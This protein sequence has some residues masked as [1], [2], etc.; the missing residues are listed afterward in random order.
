[1]GAHRQEMHTT[2]VLKGY[3]IGRA[4][5]L[6]WPVSVSKKC[7]VEF[8][9]AGRATRWA[10]PRPLSSIVLRYKKINCRMS[11][12]LLPHVYSAPQLGCDL[13]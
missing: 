7:T 6:A 5:T 12:F 1:M 8:A 2:L 10:L 9:Y 3:S 13:T 11:Q 4:L